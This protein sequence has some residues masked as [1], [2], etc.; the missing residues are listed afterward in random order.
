[1]IK[2]KTPEEIRKTFRSARHTRA[3]TPPRQAPQLFFPFYCVIPPF[4][5]DA[6]LYSIKNDF[7]PEEEAQVI[8]ENRWIEDG[9][10]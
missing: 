2:G 6:F 4:F 9:G 1:M 7:T 8:E 5:C 3:P 10:L